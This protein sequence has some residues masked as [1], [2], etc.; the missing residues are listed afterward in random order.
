M[1]WVVVRYVTTQQ[2]GLNHPAANQ[3]LYKLWSTTWHRLQKASHLSW[4]VCD[5][6]SLKHILVGSQPWS[7]GSREVISYLTF[8]LA[9]PWA[10]S[11]RCSIGTD[12][13]CSIS[14]EFRD[15][16]AQ[17]HL[18]HGLDLS[19]SRDVIGHVIIWCARCDFLLVFHWHQPAILSCLRDIKP[20]TYLGRILDLQDH[21]TSS[22]SS[23]KDSWNIIHVSHA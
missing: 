4:T 5:I 19:R 11:F 23:A 16:E 7:S 6:L 8:R 1:R 20:E 15:I 22:E 10:T 18:G 14:K 17:R 3:Y 21:V 2:Y 9:M 12:T 13:L